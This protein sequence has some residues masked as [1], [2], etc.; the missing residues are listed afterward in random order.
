MDVYGV[1]PATLNDASILLK[2]LEKDQNLVDLIQAEDVMILDR[3]FRDAL[4]NLKTKYKIETKMPEF[5]LKS[6][7]QFSTKQANISRLSTKI[8]WVVEATNSKI[9]QA[10]RALDGVVQNKALEHLMSDFR[11]AAALVNR[12]GTRLHSDGSPEKSMQIANRMIAA[13]DNENKLQEIVDEFGLHRQK[14]QFKQ[15]EDVELDEFP[16]LSHETL[17][18]EIT[19]GSFQLKFGPSYITEF[20]KRH[21]SFLL[22]C[23]K[24]LGNHASKIISAKVHSRHSNSKSYRVY[25][26]YQPQGQNSSQENPKAIEGWYCECKNGART[27]GCCCHVASI[28]FFLAFGKYQAKQKAPGEYLN[29]IF[30]AR[31]PNNEDESRTHTT[32][33]QRQQQTQTQSQNILTRPVLIADLL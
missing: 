2:V 21:G 11:I 20:H 23:S 17:S 31:G 14:S 22:C 24:Q 13:R 8:R 29:R 27:L 9:K 25:I 1:F 28:I 10:F 30:A 6:Q 26:Q 16:R 12:F 5:L 15:I 33:T 3:G 19:F 4:D 32:Q 7:K 18:S